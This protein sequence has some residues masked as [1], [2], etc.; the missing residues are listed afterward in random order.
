M[1]EVFH[2]KHYIIEMK[3]AGAFLDALSEVYN[4]KD[5]NSGSI[6]GYVKKKKLKLWPKFWFEGT[7]GTKMGEIHSSKTA[8]KFYDARKQL[9]ATI[10]E[11]QRSPRNKKKSL[12][13]VVLFVSGLPLL[14]L[15]TVLYY[16]TAFSL[17][18]FA[19][20][21]I[22]VALTAFGIYCL[23]S[24]FE[25]P[26][27]YVENPEGQKLAEI[28][29]VGRFLKEYQVL[30]PEAAVIAHIHKKRGLSAFRY[31]YSIDI[32]SEV[33]ESRVIIG[34]TILMADIDKTMA[35]SAPSFSTI[36]V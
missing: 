8:Y 3:L 17:D 30:S 28:K 1:I 32:I 29:D 14:I 19:T 23:V 31:S 24:T 18:F 10:I 12:L 11:K 7:D 15:A 21:L 25:K 6:L 2:K 20:V 34:F 33:V 9:R 27:W 35:T 36:V 22:G 16:H 26:E 4:V 5:A 13:G